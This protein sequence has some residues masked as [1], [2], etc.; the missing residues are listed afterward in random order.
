MAFPP[1]T[2]ADIKDHTA[3]GS[4][5]R[6]EEYLADGHVRSVKQTDEHTLKAQVQGSDV[7]PYLVTITFDAEDVQSV[8]CTCPYYE[9][10]WCKHIVAVLLNV[11]RE[12][13][14]PTEEP[15]EVAELTEGLDRADLVALIER[16]V[17]YDPSLL[18]QIERER[19]R[20]VDE[21]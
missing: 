9:G 3:G 12:G 8:K 2:R 15:A 16:L 19:A 14:I 6:G 11:L 1:L 7:H 5:E 20:L 4:F 13:G 17:E 18:D 10:S 21:A